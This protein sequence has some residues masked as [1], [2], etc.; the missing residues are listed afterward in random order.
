L[1]HRLNGNVNVSAIKNKTLFLT[2]LG[3]KPGKRNGK[4][5]DFLQKG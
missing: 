1:E 3:L 4:K 5:I 2:I